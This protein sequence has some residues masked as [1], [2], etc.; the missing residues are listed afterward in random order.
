M[1]QVSSSCQ[2][3]CNDAPPETC[4]DG[5]MSTIRLCT[6][7]ADCAGDPGHR[8]NCCSFGSNPLSWC[9]KDQLAASGNCTLP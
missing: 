4:S 2:S 1:A 7:Q 9:V 3:S 5:S 8:T 6:A